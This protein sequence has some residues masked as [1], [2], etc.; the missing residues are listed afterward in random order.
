MQIARKISAEKKTCQ[1]FNKK[2]LLLLLRR[3]ICRVVG[4]GK[5]SP[6]CTLLTQRTRCSL[7]FKSKFKYLI[8]CSCLI[9]CKNIHLWY[10]T[11]F[12][13]FLC[14]GRRILI[15]VNLYPTEWKYGFFKQKKGKGGREVVFRPC[16]RI[17]FLSAAPVGL[18]WSSSSIQGCCLC[19]SWFWQLLQRTHLRG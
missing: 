8:C 5:C 13:L 15:L 6:C 14:S 18:A 2:N 10:R 1:D 4:V 9:L 3:T 7:R 16:D 17:L 19:H 11:F 12:S